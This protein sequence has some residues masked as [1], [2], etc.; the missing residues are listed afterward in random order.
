MILLFLGSLVPVQVRHAVQYHGNVYIFFTTYN[1][2]CHNIKAI[3]HRRPRHVE[4]HLVGV[5]GHAD[6][7]GGGE[8]SEPWPGSN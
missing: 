5:C 3:L 2:W 7:F 4:S 6:R 1:T 8:W